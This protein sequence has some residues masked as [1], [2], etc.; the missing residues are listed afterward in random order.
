MRWNRELPTKEG[1]YWF[2]QPILSR[3]GKYWP[4]LLANIRING[5]G[6]DIYTFGSIRPDHVV[7]AYNFLFSEPVETPE[8]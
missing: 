1:I 8:V 5:V 2:R 7:Q 3:P 6:I 4:P